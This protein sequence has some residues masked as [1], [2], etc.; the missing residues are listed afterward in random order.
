[1]KP[2]ATRGLLAPLLAVFA[3]CG[4]CQRPLPPGLE[5]KDGLIVRVKDGAAM[6][7]V[8][9]GPFLMGEECRRVELPGFYIDQL[10]VAN[11]QYLMFA[12]STGHK[13]PEFLE[14]PSANSQRQPVVGVTWHDAAAYAAWAGAQ[15]PSEA[16]WEKAARGTDGR[17]Y[18]WGNAPPTARLAALGSAGHEDAA[19]PV[20]SLPDGA[21]PYGCLD[22]SGNVWEWCADWFKV[23]GQQ[24]VIRGGSWGE[25]SF[26]D[27]AC[28]TRAGEYPEFMQEHIGFRCVVPD[29]AAAP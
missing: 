25:S 15:L 17:M 20:G 1:M 14:L 2:F 4:G 19:L 24:R 27:G 10:E 3:A 28:Y 11:V 12:A 22:M 26:G 13:P 16:Q 5:Y 21:S 18:P 23:P 9:A 7:Y 6:V 29:V 8:P